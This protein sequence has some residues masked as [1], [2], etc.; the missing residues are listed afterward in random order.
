MKE[1]SGSS[2]DPVDLNIEPYYNSGATSVR[3]LAGS[4]GSKYSLMTNYLQQKNVRVLVDPVNFNTLSPF[5]NL[6]CFR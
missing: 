3:V 1:L 6:I 5:L 4:C 2:R